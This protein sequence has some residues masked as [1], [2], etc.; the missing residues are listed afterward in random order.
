M[1][2][3]GVGFRNLGMGGPFGGGDGN[4]RG[5]ISE[6]LIKVPFSDDC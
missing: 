3:V 4:C 2:G 6:T 1:G 5:G